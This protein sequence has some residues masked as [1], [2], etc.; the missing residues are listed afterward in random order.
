MLI[1]SATTC[2]SGVIE[3]SYDQV[4]QLGVCPPAAGCHC[5]SVRVKGLL[6][7]GKDMCPTLV[8]THTYTI[9]AGRDSGQVGWVGVSNQGEGHVSN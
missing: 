6:T 3:G 4:Q 7:V 1:K 8:H 5:Q 2:D 9:P